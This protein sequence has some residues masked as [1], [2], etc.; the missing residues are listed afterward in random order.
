MIGDELWI[1]NPRAWL[2]ERISSFIL[3]FLSEGNGGEK[4]TQAELARELEISCS[5]MGNYISESHLMS[6]VVLLRLSEVAGVSIDEILLHPNSPFSQTDRQKALEAKKRG[7]II[8]EDGKELITHDKY[9]NK[10][11]IAVPAKED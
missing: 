3:A 6:V 9:G 10:L 1:T 8:T 4:M 11:L 2:K 7:I 5:L